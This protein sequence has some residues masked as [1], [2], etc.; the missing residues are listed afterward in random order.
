MGQISLDI[1]SLHQQSI[2]T[3]GD[4]GWCGA[5]SLTPTLIPSLNNATR[6]MGAGN[7]GTQAL[8]NPI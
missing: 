2:A 4:K 6:S 1:L 8:V 5:K 7:G 3:S